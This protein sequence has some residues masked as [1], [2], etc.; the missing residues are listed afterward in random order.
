RDR[1]ARGLPDKAGGEAT[2]ER[3][4]REEGEP[5]V[6]RLNPGGADA[7]VPH[8]ASPL[9]GRFGFG[10]RAI[11]H[12]RTPEHGL[13]SFGEIDAAAADWTVAGADRVVGGADALADGLVALHALR[14]GRRPRR[15]RLPRA[16]RAASSRHGPATGRE[17][18]AEAGCRPAEGTD[19]GRDAGLDDAGK[20][21]RA[22]GGG[23]AA[24]DR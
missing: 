15:L 7:L 20:P 11:A 13:F 12:G 18:F 16:R 17:T 19:R 3:E 14:P 9:I 23:G 10:G 4:H 8:L 22:I 24:R 5:P 2:A 21:A 6:H 1:A